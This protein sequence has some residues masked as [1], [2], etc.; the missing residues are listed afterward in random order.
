MVK[1]YKVMK[2]GE[3]YAVVLSADEHARPVGE[4]TYSQRTHAYRRC[5]KLNKAA[6]EIDEMIKR[7]GAIIL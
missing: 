4:K 5:R 1:T 2:I 3:K 6:R 7:D